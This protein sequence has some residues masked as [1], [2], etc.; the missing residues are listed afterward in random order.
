[1]PGNRGARGWDG[2]DSCL[3]DA[4]EAAH[5]VVVNGA[6]APYR[7]SLRYAERPVE[8]PVDMFVHT[9]ATWHA[10]V[11]REVRTLRSPLLWMCADGLLLF[12][13]DGL[14]ARIAA[15]ALRLTTAGPPPLSA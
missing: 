13:T 12:D 9:D 11:E 7:A 8:W 1:M 6:P 3:M 4:I 2:A 5:A 14:G 10:Y 15:E